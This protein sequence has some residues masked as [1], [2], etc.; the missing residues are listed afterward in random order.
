M[1]KKCYNIYT[2]HFVNML[3]LFVIVT[4]TFLKCMRHFG[5]VWNKPGKRLDLFRRSIAP[6]SSIA[7]FF[8]YTKFLLYYF[9]A[10]QHPSCGT[11]LCVPFINQPEILE[12]ERR[13]TNL[14]CVSVFH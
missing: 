13:L 2:S 7:V 3:S 8:L 14:T 1:Y 12:I 6:R 11:H 4:M 10:Q 5:E 9:R